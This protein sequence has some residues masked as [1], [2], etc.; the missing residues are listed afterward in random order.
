MG[1][2]HAPGW[3]ATPAQLVGFFSAEPISAHALAAQ[4]NAVV[5]DSYEELLRSVDVVDVCTPTPLHHPLVLQAAAAGKAIVCEKPLAR[6]TAQAAEMIAA[7]EQAGVPL[8]VAHVVR[9]FPEY[10]VAQGIVARGEIGRVAVIR[11][12]RASFKPNADDP[13]SWF[14]DPAQSGG[15]LMDLMIHDYDYARWIGGEVE[16]VFARS[17]L[18]QRPEIGS[19]LW[20]GDPAAQERRAV[21][22]RRWLGLPAAAVPHGA[23]N[24]GRPRPDRASS[25]KQHAAGAA[26]ARDG[27][28]WRGDCRARQPAG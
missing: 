1:R 27:R 16:T 24:C 2:T 12:T 26:H 19:R 20:A 23:R 25:R 3:R 22:R 7:C 21:T 4:H 11:L 14:H 18:A 5:F 13:T 10:A 15:M 28:R 17:A 9:F 8:L 6:T